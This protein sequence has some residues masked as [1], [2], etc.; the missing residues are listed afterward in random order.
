MLRTMILLAIVVAV[1]GI[2]WLVL[3]KKRFA[4]WTGLYDPKDEMFI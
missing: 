4:K 2:A 1:L 3:S